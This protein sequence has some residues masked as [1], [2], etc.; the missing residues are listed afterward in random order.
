M[1]D[2]KTDR[3]PHDSLPEDVEVDDPT[4]APGIPQARS[5]AVV[6]QG[7]VGAA[8]VRAALLNKT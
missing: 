7:G 5:R 3:G 8:V 4:K 6:G 1:M 2:D